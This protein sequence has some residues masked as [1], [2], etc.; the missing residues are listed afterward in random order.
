MQRNSTAAA[1]RTAA[2]G[3]HFEVVIGALMYKHSR[4]VG[5]PVLTVSVSNH[6]STDKLYV[7]VTGIL[8]IGLGDIQPWA[9]NDGVTNACG[10]DDAK[11]GDS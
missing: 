6:D 5:V 9:Q 3:G 7:D 8:H 10:W 11:H 4:D 1:L 2:A